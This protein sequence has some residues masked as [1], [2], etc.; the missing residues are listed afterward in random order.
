MKIMGCYQRF[1]KFSEHIFTKNHMYI[2]KNFK[3]AK[4][5][6]IANDLAV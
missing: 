6:D 2:F 5:N 3:I 1:C 4:S